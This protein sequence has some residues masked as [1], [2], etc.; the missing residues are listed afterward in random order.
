MSHLARSSIGVEL[1]NVFIL[2]SRAVEY[3]VL[4][5]LAFPWS[6]SILGMAGG[7]ITTL[8]VAAT[9]LYTSLI[10]WKYCMVHPHIR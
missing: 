5:I 10:L 7:V 6:Y 4:A 8:I 2:S 3:V 9:T 1:T